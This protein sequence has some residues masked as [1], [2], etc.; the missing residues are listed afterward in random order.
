MV[1]ADFIQVISFM[2][3]S[4]V[5]GWCSGFLMLQFKRMADYI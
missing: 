1:E 2:T 5:L 4:Y 3:G